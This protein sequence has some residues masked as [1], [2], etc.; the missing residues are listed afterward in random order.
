M[1]PAVGSPV[2]AKRSRC[3]RRGVEGR[4]RGARRTAKKLRFISRGKKALAHP[5][6]LPLSGGARGRAA[7]AGTG[8]RG[9]SSGR[10][11][12]AVPAAGARTR[13]AGVFCIHK[14]KPVSRGARALSLLILLLLGC[15]TPTVSTPFSLSLSLLWSLY[16]YT[17]SPGSCVSPHTPHTQ[18]LTK[19]SD[20]QSHTVS[21]TRH[22]ATPHRSTAHR[23]HTN[24]DTHACACTCLTPHTPAPLWAASSSPVHRARVAV[25]R[26][27]ATVRPRRTPDL[28]YSII[29]RRASRQCRDGI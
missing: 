29:A 15:G 3:R 17:R 6:P 27:C 4:R 16:M 28:T 8:E 14:I 18:R 22:T 20:A 5:S 21:P 25:G 13:A 19:S 26:A 1:P 12:G 9:G 10:P 23:A 11:P 2:V 24:D 7:R